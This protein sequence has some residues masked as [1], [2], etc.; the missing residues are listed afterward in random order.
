MSFSFHQLYFFLSLK[1]MLTTLALISHISTGTFLKIRKVLVEL[2]S[3]LQGLQQQLRMVV[4][5]I[6]ENMTKGAVHY[7]WRK[8]TKQVRL[9][10][11]LEGSLGVWNMGMKEESAK[12]I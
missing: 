9:E 6:S 8:V 5:T 2:F 4:Q 11:G 7:A 12:R 1:Q 10:L 3:L